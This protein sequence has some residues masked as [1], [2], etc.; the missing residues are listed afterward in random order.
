MT[1]TEESLMALADAL[2]ESCYKGGDALGTP[3]SRDR[4]REAV[5][6]AIREVLAELD[7]IKADRAAKTA[8]MWELGREAEKAEAECERLRNDLSV[9]KRLLDDKIADC[10]S[11][12]NENE[13]LRKDAERYR[14]L[15]TPGQQQDF[16]CGVA[17]DS[18][19][20]MDAAIDAAIKDQ[21]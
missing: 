20:E 10:V 16:V 2:I 6:L 15:H 12:I 3:S 14:W 13:R 7:R 4:A 21:P 19:E 17:W 1:H 8:R 11:W 9:H 18:P 5:R